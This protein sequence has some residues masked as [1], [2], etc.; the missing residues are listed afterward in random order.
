MTL[1]QAQL[2]IESRFLSF[3]DWK[4][5]TKLDSCWE[6]KRG[7]SHE[8]GVFNLHARTHI[9]SRVSY[10]IY[11]TNFKD[12]FLR[13]DS[14]KLYVMHSCDNRSCVNPCHLSLGTPQQNTKDAFDKGRIK[15]PSLGKKNE[16]AHNSKITMQTANE[17]RK[18]YKEEK[19]SQ[20][21][22]ARQY[23]I[24]GALVSLI[25]TNKIWI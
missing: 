4:D 13:K 10:W 16:L 8:Y 2:N 12:G 7:R 6:W 20:T 5:T 3:I 19:I 23:N 25:V 18:R 14:R 15:H 17:I 21:N 24:S 11:H 1:E 22:L 9:A